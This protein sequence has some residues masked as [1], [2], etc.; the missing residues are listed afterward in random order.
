M[1]QSDLN[2]ARLAIAGYIRTETARLLKRARGKKGVSQE[3]LAQGIGES[4]D[5]IRFLES[6]KGMPSLK[7]LHGNLRKK[8]ARYFNFNDI[9][10]DFLSSLEVLVLMMKCYYMA[11]DTQLERLV[12]EIM[13]K[14]L[15]PFRQKRRKEK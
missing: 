12:N 2:E 10:D 4:P 5:F 11:N 9:E 7:D 6:G 15:L 1:E 13:K 3:E 14:K 8:L